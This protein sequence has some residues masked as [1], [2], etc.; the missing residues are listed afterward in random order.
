LSLRS[1][2]YD[3]GLC[4]FPKAAIEYALDGTY[5]RL[6]AI[7]GVDDE[8]AFNQRKGQPPTAVELRIEADGQEIFKRIVKAP[9][10]PF[11]LDLNVKGVTTMKVIV[12]FGDGNSTCDYLDLV[13]AKLLVDATKE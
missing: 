2:A 7:V 10:D 4:I 13:D 1:R 6:T 3:K 12:D 9:E 8:V 11:S 5:S